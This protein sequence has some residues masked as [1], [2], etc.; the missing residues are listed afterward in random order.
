MA[1][2]LPDSALLALGRAADVLGRASDL[3]AI[4]SQ[5]AADTA[6]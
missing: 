5:G 6:R 3:D 4:L 1:R 2:D